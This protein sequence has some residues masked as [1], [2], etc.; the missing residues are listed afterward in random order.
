MDRNQRWDWTGNAKWLTTALGR[1][2]THCGPPL[3]F[4]RDLS[5]TWPHQVR[6]ARGA[7]L[8]FRLVLSGC[9]SFPPF[10][11]PVHSSLVIANDGYCRIFALCH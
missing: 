6:T 4:S 5:W 8:W 3:N 10:P 11:P 2:K 7:A 1:D 9:F